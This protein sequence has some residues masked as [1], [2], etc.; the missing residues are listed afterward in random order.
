[1]VMENRIRGGDWLDFGDVLKIKY[2][3]VVREMDIEQNAWQSF[4]KCFDD[5]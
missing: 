5:Q 3:N 4:K 1:M 2:T